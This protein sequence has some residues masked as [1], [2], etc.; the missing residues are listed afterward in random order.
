VLVGGIVIDHQMNVES[1]CNALLHMPQKAQVFLM[2]VPG[3]TLSD[4]I[5]ISDIQSSKERRGAVPLIVVGDTLDVS[6]AHREHGLS[7]LQGLNPTLL[8]DAEHYGI[9]GWTYSR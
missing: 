4:D 7:S 1:W 8:V 6:Q 9:L 3:F 5:A 2:S